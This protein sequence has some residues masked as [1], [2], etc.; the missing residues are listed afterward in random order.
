M[1]VEPRNGPGAAPGGNRNGP[2]GPGGGRGRGGGDRDR[3]QRG[4]RGGPQAG[5]AD[6]GEMPDKKLRQLAVA[7]A[8]KPHLPGFGGQLTQLEIA[9]RARNR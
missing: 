9:R 1:A 4:G 2:G 8:H 6:G 5:G 3:N 7:V